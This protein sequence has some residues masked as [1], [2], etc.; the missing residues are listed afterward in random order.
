MAKSTWALHLISVMLLPTHFSIWELSLSQ[1][2]HGLKE[3]LYCH[4]DKGQ[5]RDLHKV[6]NSGAIN[7]YTNV[8]STLKWRADLVVVKNLEINSLH[9]V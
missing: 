4:F 6:S 5:I 7:V 3:D 8:V 2:D 9:S 1:T